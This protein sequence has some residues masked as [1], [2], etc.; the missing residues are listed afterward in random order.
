MYVLLSFLSTRANFCTRHVVH[1][2]QIITT[3]ILR[4]PRCAINRTFLPPRDNFAETRRP[5]NRK[6]PITMRTV[7]T[8]VRQQQLVK[9]S[10]HGN[11]S[12]LASHGRA[13]ACVPP[14]PQTYSPFSS[15]PG[16][17][18][19]IG[20]LYLSAARDASS[21]ARCIPERPGRPAARAPPPPLLA[22]FRE[23]CCC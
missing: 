19:F 3:K 22:F 23:A 12:C 15:F 16:I 7:R 17:H 9:Q 8:T 20:R 1:Q 11:N 5:R 2:Q 10:Q 13:A 18:R 6:D 4:N 14:R 21:E